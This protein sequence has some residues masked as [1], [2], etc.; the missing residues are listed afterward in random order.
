MPPLTLPRTSLCSTTDNVIPYWLRSVLKPHMSPS[1]LELRAAVLRNPKGPAVFALGG[2]EADGGAPA[3]T[4]PTGSS[5]NSPKSVTSSPTGSSINSCE[6]AA[7]GG[8]G[9]ATAAG[10]V[11]CAK[12]STAP[13]IAMIKMEENI[14]WSRGLPALCTVWSEESRCRRTTTPL[15]NLLAGNVRSNQ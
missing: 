13:N 4:A 11:H 7:A 14:T 6:L 15:Y 5:M 3:T 1:R 8:A 2:G 10:A 12:A 9:T